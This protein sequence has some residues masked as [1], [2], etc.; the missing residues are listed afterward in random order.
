[1]K[2]IEMYRI[3]LDKRDRSLPHPLTVPIIQKVSREFG[4][5]FLY[6]NFNFYFSGL[7]VH[8][9]TTMHYVGVCNNYCIN[10]FP[11]YIN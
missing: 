2:F 9:V 7:G 6:Y 10:L 8:H 4:I 3:K 5:S 1:M 11:K